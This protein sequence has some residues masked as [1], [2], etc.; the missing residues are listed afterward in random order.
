[1]VWVAAGEEGHVH[2][3]AGPGQGCTECPGE[4]LVGARS[5]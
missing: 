1:M 3:G 5:A 2:Q 4:E